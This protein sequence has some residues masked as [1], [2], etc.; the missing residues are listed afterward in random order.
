[1]VAMQDQIRVAFLLVT[2]GADS[3]SLESPPEGHRYTRDAVRGV[4]QLMGCKPRHAYKILQLMFQH[5]QQ[6]LPELSKLSYRRGSWGVFPHGDD[7]VYVSMPRQE[8]NDLLCSCLAEYKYKYA[9][10]SDE[11]KV[12]CRYAILRVSLKW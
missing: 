2:K 9:P 6:K 8:F 12:A 4:L 1:M 10:S 11:L 5:V 3:H 7:Q